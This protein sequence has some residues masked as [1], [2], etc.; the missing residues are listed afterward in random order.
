RLAAHDT[1]MTV[2]LPRGP[3]QREDR[4]MHRLAGE[5]DP[6]EW[7]SAAP[8]SSSGAD[9]ARI[10]ALEQKIESLSEQVETLIRRLDEIE[11]N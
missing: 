2:R 5:I 6:A 3:G 9:E 11:A 7:V 4:Y 10:D 1:P 8:Q